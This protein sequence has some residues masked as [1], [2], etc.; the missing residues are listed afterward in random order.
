VIAELDS[1]GAHFKS[2]ADPID[3]TTPQ[4]RFALQ[5]LGAVAARF[6]PGAHQGRLARR[7]RNAAASSA[8]QSSMPATATPSSASS[9]PRRRT[10]SSASIERPNIGC[11]SFRECAQI[12]A[13]R[14]SCALLNAKRESATGA[15][16]P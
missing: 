15:P 5:V 11:R 12:I 7:R 2:L 10:I 3:T 9:T 13:G 4:G 1:K 14:M 6:D 8:I 16:L